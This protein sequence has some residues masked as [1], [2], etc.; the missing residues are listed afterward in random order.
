MALEAKLIT[1][2]LY[3]DLKWDGVKWRYTP[4]SKYKDGL[5][6]SWSYVLNDGNT[7]S[8]A[9]IEYYNSKNNIPVAINPVILL[10][11]RIKNTIPVYS[12]IQDDGLIPNAA[13]FLYVDGAKNGKLSLNTEKNILYYE[14]NNALYNTENISYTIT[15][16][17]Y[18]ANGNFTIKYIAPI[19]TG[20]KITNY[21]EYLKTLVE[22]FSI[23]PP[24]SGNWN[25]TTN[26][27][28]SISADWAV[29]ETARY[30][31]AY[32]YV[33]SNQ[34][35]LIQSFG[36]NFNYSSLTS[37]IQTKYASW[38]TV[39]IDINNLITL[40]SPLTA[41]WQGNNALLISKYFNWNNDSDSYSKLRTLY[42]SNTG[43]YE[44]T[45]QLINSLSSTFDP[46]SFISFYSTA[47]S[48]WDD[49][50]N[51]LLTKRS[52]FGFDLFAT[53]KYDSFVSIIS[54]LSSS[55]P[56]LY[57]LTT[58]K[59]SLWSANASVSAISATAL[60]GSSTQNL[61]T[62]DLHG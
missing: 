41:I 24:V 11:P 36:K 60:S 31:S 21:V 22:T 30:N 8:S 13:K 46:T 28:S 54:S 2:P 3:G 43:K 23:V 14:A 45:Y 53:R 44:V 29:L 51:T 56:S 25:T 47:S 55:I 34:T 37:I 49:V 12:L 38:D 32:D 4:N 19:F 20:K 10:D 9:I 50:T 7:V 62:K 57:N 52:T 16:G 58:T 15:D 48:K 1:S 35:F 59:N 5:T 18:T 27:V 33:D 40:I 26:I 42:S 6:D 39:L 61:R 17:Q